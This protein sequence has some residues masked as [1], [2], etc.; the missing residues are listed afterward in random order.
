MSI[1]EIQRSLVTVKTVRW[2]VHVRQNTVNA[3]I[4]ICFILAFT[5]I[6]FYGCASHVILELFKQNI[7][8]LQTTLMN[9]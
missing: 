4:N 8:R 9:A 5:S 1:T 7:S 6:L 2:S 3:G